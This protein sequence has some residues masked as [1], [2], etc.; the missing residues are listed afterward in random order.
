[1]RR[2]GTVVVVGLW[3]L[4]ALAA[5][6]VGVAWSGHVGRDLAVYL[7]AGR[8]VLHGGS[9]YVDR[10]DYPPAFLPFAVALAALP[11]HTAGTVMVVAL[12]SAAV[13]VG[14][15][16]AAA[17]G[18]RVGGPAAPLAVLAVLVSAPFASALRVG[19]V[20]PVLAVFAGATLVL[21]VRH[22]P[23][24][25]GV[26]LGVSLA[27]KP[28]LAPLALLLLVPGN[29]RGLL[30]AIGVP[31]VLSV[32]A[33]A[34]TGHLAAFATA[35]LPLIFSSSRSTASNIALTG[36]LRY[37]ALGLALVVAWRWR[38][39]PVV[40]G[41]AMM[42]GGLAYGPVTWVHYLLVLSPGAVWVVA[43]AGRVVSGYA[44]Q[45]QRGRVERELV[46]HADELIGA[47]RIERAKDELSGAGAQ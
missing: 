31:A 39:R 43:S 20:S 3:L 9:G 41:T 38:D 46:E 14:I 21:L 19:N 44:R 10:F 1:V 45:R 8:D 17:A 7:A 12:L 13:G 24:A 4:V 23:V 6:T 27:L 40:A 5:V 29:R 30:P 11:T 37:V 42:A 26:V 25:A 35:G 16:S 15:T 22:R 47:A 34:A 33:A 28:M 2:G 18:W 32:A 36:A